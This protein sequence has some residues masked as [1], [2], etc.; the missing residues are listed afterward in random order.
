MLGGIVFV[1]M[2]RTGQAIGSSNGDD[3]VPDEDDDEDE[4]G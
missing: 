1:T 4:T 3:A 2:T